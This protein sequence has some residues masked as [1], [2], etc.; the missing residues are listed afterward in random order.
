LPTST[1]AG[2]VLASPREFVPPGTVTRGY[3]DTTWGQLAALRAA[4]PELPPLFEVP[5]RVLRAGTCPNSSRVYFELATRRPDDPSGRSPQGTLFGKPCD[6]TRLQAGD[7]WDSAVRSANKRIDDHL[8]SLATPLTPSEVPDEPLLD[9]YNAQ[10]AKL[11][12]MTGFGTLS[13]DSFRIR[14]SAIPRA[15]NGKAG[16]PAAQGP[17]T[18]S[19]TSTVKPDGHWIA[20][21]AL[22]AAGGIFEAKLSPPPAEALRST[23]ATYGLL[24]EQYYEL[25]FDLG[26][27]LTWNGSAGK[28]QAEPYL[29]GEA[30]R[31]LCLSNIP[32][33]R[34]LLVDGGKLT[35]ARRRRAIR[36]KTVLIR[37]DRP[38]R[39]TTCPDCKFFSDCKPR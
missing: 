30:D 31:Q 37:P 36:W 29:I 27:S 17:T 2:F 10:L 20:L 18:S 39:F 7:L 19:A 21:D 8:G 9:H 32:L 4:L 16:A 26:V 12:R 24:A 11:R 35:G 38:A 28:P 13:I 33:L 25:N 14:Q 1:W 3:E 34:K 22:P 15:R 23:F 6:L 5:V